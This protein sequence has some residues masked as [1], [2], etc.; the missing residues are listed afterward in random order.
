MCSLPC[1]GKADGYDFRVINV[2][3]GLKASGLKVADGYDFRVINVESGLKASGLKVPAG[4]CSRFEQTVS[5]SAVCK[6]INLI[7]QKSVNL[8]FNT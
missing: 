8:I 2:E 4:G 5:Y 6:T 7:K 3:S 1:V